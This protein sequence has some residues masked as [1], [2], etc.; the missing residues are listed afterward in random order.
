M[1]N[2]QEHQK[3]PD[4]QDTVQPAPHI[5]PRKSFSLFTRSPTTDE[6]TA[7]VS[8]LKDALEQHKRIE[9]DLR[10]ELREKGEE[11]L[12]VGRAGIGIVRSDCLAY[13]RA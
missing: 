13:V 9:S 5:S 1:R 8:Q 10:E 12:L 11:D 3:R 4:I 7:E 6:T 2:V